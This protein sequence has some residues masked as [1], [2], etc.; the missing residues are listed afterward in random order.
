VEDNVPEAEDS[1]LEDQAEEVVSR[2]P[3]RTFTT[4]PPRLAVQP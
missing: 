3:W 1:V 4:D 2:T